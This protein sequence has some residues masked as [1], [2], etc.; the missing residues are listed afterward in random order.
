MLSE[1]I[2]SSLWKRGLAYGTRV[3]RREE[4]FFKSSGIGLEVA[5]Q[6]GLPQWRQ[7]QEKVSSQILQK[8]PL[9]MGGHV[10]PLPAAAA[11]TDLG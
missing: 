2:P 10:T 8:Q 11:R 6:M 4:G 5:V 1:V 3:V 9:G 7:F